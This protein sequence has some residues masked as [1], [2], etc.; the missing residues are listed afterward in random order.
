MTEEKDFYEAIVNKKSLSDR[1]LYDLLDYE[2]DR[3]Y[4]DNRRWTRSVSS[5][6]ELCGHLF[7]LD[8]D[9]GLTEYQDDVFFDL[10][11]EVVKEEKQVTTTVVTYVP[12]KEN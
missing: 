4:G 2:V 8:W 10:P 5:I 3:S 7:E 12:L 11:Y 9:E 6:L 1:E